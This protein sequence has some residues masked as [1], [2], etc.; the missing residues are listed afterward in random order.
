MNIFATIVT[1][2]ATVSRPI[3]HLIIKLWN[4]S[5]SYVYMVT[6]REEWEVGWNMCVWWGG[7]GEVAITGGGRLHCNKKIRQKKKKK[8]NTYTPKR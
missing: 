3:L 5:Y 6:R 2:I 8:T 1:L 7:G 4:E